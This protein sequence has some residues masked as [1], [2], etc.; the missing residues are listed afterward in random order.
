VLTH[1]K[2]CALFERR[3]QAWLREDLD[4]YLALFAQDMSFQSPS[5]AEPLRGRAAFAELVQRSLASTR[6]TEFEFDHLAIEG[7]FVLAEWRIAVETRQAARR[8]A[9]RGMSV[10]EIR[11]EQIT[12]WR[13]YWNPADLR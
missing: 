1:E 8:I 9:W 12:M 6:P 4:G 3:R 10:C 11:D 13:E 2:A 7:D 5:H